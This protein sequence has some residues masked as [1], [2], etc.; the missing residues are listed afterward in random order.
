MGR[1]P[2]PTQREM[3]GERSCLPCKSK[4][5]E[6]RLDPRLK[7]CQRLR[8]MGDADPD[9]PGRAGTGKGTETL[10]DQANRTTPN[11]RCSDHLSDGTE[12]TL[13]NLSQEFERKM[14]VL[15]P[16]PS[17]VGA[18]GLEPILHPGQGCLEA[19]IQIDGDK[20]ANR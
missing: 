13:L 6:P 15:R 18:G 19:G 8:A 5:L 11:S 10:K 2:H 17:N 12:T 20:D 4:R 9:D 1:A 16:H 7:R 3:R 14:E